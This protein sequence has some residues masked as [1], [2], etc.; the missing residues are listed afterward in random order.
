MAEPVITRATFGV[1][2]NAVRLVDLF[3]LFLSLVT[4]RVTV[5]VELQRQFSVSALQFLISCVPIDAEHLII[6]SFAHLVFPSHCIYLSDALTRFSA[7][8]FQLNALAGA[9]AR[10]CSSK[11]AMKLTAPMARAYSILTGPTMPKL[12][13]IWSP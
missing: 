13:M 1:R 12:P 8:G 7:T 5:R 4:S 10:A 11:R 6:V 3:E 9:L 2:E